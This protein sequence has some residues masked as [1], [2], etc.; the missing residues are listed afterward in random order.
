MCTAHVLFTQNTKRDVIITLYKK[1]YSDEP[2]IKLFEDQLPEIH[3]AQNT[4]FCCMGGF[5]IDDNNRLVIIA[6]ID[7]LV[8]G[9]S[10]QAVQNMNLML[11][12][13]ETEV[14]L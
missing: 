10:G 6:T 7:N 3:D 9:A 8:K 5:E 4:N 14:L 11:G 2:F 1:Y 13:E 12:F